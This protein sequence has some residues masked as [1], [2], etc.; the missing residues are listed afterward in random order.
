MARRDSAGMRA[1]DMIHPTLIIE[2]DT[3]PLRTNADGVVLVGQTRVP[4]DTV[5]YFFNE[6]DTPETIVD[7]FSSLDLADVY[8]VIGYYLRHRPAV[9]GYLRQRD[10]LAAEV[11]RETEARFSQ[12]GLRERL[13]ARLANGRADAPKD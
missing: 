13:L 7:K 1:N 5:V 12:V 3:V 9:D 11:R 6:G 4:I 8:A 2:P 10:E